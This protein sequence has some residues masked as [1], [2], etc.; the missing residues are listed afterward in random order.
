M[1]GPAE[2]GVVVSM[3][4]WR[5][6]VHKSICHYHRNSIYRDL[7]VSPGMLLRVCRSCQPSAEEV[8][9]YL[10]MALIKRSAFSHGRRWVA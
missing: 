8:D 4:S 6:T 1:A 2:M 9:A 5:V 7:S 10:D 3:G